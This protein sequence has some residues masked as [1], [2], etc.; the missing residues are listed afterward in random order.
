MASKG[1]LI[2]AHKD[3]DEI[4]R[5]IDADSLGYLSLEGTV[6]ATRQGEGRLCTGCFTGSYPREVPLQLD[7]FALEADEFRD[8]HAMPLRAVT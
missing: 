6:A 7:K 1:E 2:A 4:R 3:V 8:R 5:H